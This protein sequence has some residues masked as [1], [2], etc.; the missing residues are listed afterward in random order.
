MEGILVISLESGMLL[1]QE[2][3]RY[4]YGL[5]GEEV[6]A[7]Q[8]SSNLFALFKLSCGDNDDSESVNWIKM[9]FIK[10]LSLIYF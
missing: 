4:N 10:I 3:L 6:D 2:A 5:D 9:V 7:L 8:L 1:Y